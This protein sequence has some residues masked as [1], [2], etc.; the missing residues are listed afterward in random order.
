MVRLLFVL[1]R[2]ST[3]RFGR[4]GEPVALRPDAAITPEAMARLQSAPFL[5]RLVLQ[6]SAANPDPPSQLMSY[7]AWEQRDVSDR[8]LDE[9]LSS[10]RERDFFDFYAAIKQLQFLL[11]HVQDSLVAQRVEYVMTRFLAL[12]REMSTYYKA[13]E[14]CIKAFLHLVQHSPAVA[15]WTKPRIDSCSWM[16]AWLGK[17]KTLPSVNRDGTPKLAAGAD[18]ARFAVKGEKHEGV[19]SKWE[20]NW[21]E[22]ITEYGV[23]LA[24]S[25]QT[26]DYQKIFRKTMLAVRTRK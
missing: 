22:Q 23:G 16:D 6:A 11:L 24:T 5:T 7:L 20:T 13:T 14:L 1:F 26:S 18:V 12:A 10:V 9:I 19:N 21:N 15:A 25:E 2:A 8:I 17:N 3:T 4:A